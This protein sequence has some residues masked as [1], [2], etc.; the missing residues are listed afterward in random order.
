ME[1]AQEPLSE[2]QDQEDSHSS[3]EAAESDCV[4]N[5]QSDFSSGGEFDNHDIHSPSE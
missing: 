4:A 1:S 5:I 3:D 2:N